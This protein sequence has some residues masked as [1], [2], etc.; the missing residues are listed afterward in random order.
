MID[1]VAYFKMPKCASTTLMHIFK[2]Y[3]RVLFFDTYKE[4]KENIE[5]KG[6]KVLKITTCRD[7]YTRAVSSWRHCKRE[8]WIPEKETLIQFLDRDFFKNNNVSYYSMPQC[9]F[10]HNFM[11]NDIHNILKI[12]DL[13][14]NIKS[15]LP[16]CD[17]RLQHANR[18]IGPEYK[19]NKEEIKKIN[20]VYKIDFVKLNYEINRI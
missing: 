15:I 19:L 14:N 12:E 13:T 20:K 6:E 5:L 11:K 8:N 9:D 18:D 3:K 16:N 7:P 10:I 17:L 4:Y 2:N 1:F